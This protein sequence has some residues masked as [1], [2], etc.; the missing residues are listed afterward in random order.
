MGNEIGTGTKTTNAASDR[1][2]LPRVQPLGRIP[3]NFVKVYGAFTKY[4]DNLVLKASA[5]NRGDDPELFIDI[6]RP[7]PEF[8]SQPT[9]TRSSGERGG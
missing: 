9:T 2:P 6:E 4:P 5:Q 7:M 8:K 3:I 1:K